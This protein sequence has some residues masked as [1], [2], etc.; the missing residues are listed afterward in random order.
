MSRRPGRMTRVIARRRKRERLAGIA[1]ALVGV[2]VLVVAIVALRDPNQGDVH[3]GTHV[4]SPSS[5]AKTS[6]SSSTS[7]STSPS[8]TDSTTPA[9]SSTTTSSASKLPLVVLNNTTTTGLAQSAAERFTAGG[10]T[11][12]KFDNYTN[13]I[14]STCAYYD[15]AVS[16]AQES[17]LALQAQ[18]PT[19][20]RVVPQ[21]ASLA[22]YN[23]PIVVV[24][25]PDYSAN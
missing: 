7:T 21:F 22:A 2:F 10:W 23:S 20:K 6:G 5:P 11:V 8:A 9:T 13:D 18:Y 15:P 17:A 1:L 16:G 12:T 24:L 19:I 25:T 3:A 14:L 4:A